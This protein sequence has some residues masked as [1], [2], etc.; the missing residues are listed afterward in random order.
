M[1]NTSSAV[2]LLGYEPAD[3]FPG[4]IHHLIFR[5][6]QLSGRSACPARQDPLLVLVYRANRFQLADID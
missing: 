6:A 3:L 5:L 4:N 2:M 1:V